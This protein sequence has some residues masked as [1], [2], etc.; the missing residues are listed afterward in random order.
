MSD[1]F[2]R[3]QRLIWPDLPMPT[4]RIASLVYVLLIIYASIFPFNFNVEVGA[5]ILDWVI[6]PIPRYITSFDVFTNILGYIPLGFLTVFAV[7]PRLKAYRALLFALLLGGLLSGSLESLQT[8]LS[9]RIPS[10][11]DWWA[12]MGGATLGALLA[13]PLDPKWL[14]GSGFQHRRIEWFGM[15][16]SGLI[17]LMVFPFAQ[18]YPQTAWLAMGDWGSLWSPQVPWKSNLN[19]ATLEIASTMVAWLAAGT[20]MAVTMRARAPRVRILMI[21]LVLTIIL[22]ALFSGMQF[23]V[24][25]SFTWL[26]PAAIWGMI[27]ATLLLIATLQLSHRWLYVV[28][29]LSLGCMVFLMNFFPKNPYYIGTIQEWRQGRLIHFN[30]LMAWLAWLWPIGAGLSLLR[31]MKQGLKQTLKQSF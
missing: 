19:F 29:L 10:N 26:T 18:I 23:G 22:K 17:L 1:N 31:G 3:P 24:D 9:T 7:Y 30:H 14:S 21:L 15:R 27:F 8:W 20:C 13:M 11:V 6:A 12:N 28:A 25:K 5:S 16:T 4:A 2:Q